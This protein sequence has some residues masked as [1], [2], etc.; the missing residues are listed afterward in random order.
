MVTVFDVLILKYHMLLES[1][2][3]NV[4]DLV[5]CELLVSHHP[6]IGNL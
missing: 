2:L 4:E 1:Y 5:D 3:S 6:Q